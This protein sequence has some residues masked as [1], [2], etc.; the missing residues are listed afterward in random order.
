[1]AGIFEEN[2]LSD[3]YADY[4]LERAYRACPFLIRYSNFKAGNAPQIR[5]A[6]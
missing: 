6:W 2:S 3:F 4:I 1:M 5:I